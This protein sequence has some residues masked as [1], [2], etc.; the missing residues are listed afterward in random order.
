L[1]IVYT[2]FFPGPKNTD[3]D[4]IILSFNNLWMQYG[5]RSFTL[6]ALYEG[7][8]DLSYCLGTENSL[9]AF[10]NGLEYA[11][12]VK[13][14]LGAPA[15]VLIPAEGEKPS[16]PVPFCALYYIG[17]TLSDGV[18]SLEYEEKALIA[19]GIGSYSRF[20]CDPEFRA[21]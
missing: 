7:G 17:N 4:D 18:G 13:K 19:A 8:T 1:K 9:S 2:C 12:K 21:L 20:Y 5:G 16:V 11:R 15:T 14:V 3:G 10:A 6:W